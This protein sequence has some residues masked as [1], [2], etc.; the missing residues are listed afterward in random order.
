MKKH[1]AIGF[2]SLLTLSIVN[3]A[4]A[5]PG[6][7]PAAWSGLSRAYVKARP[8]VSL[9]RPGFQDPGSISGGLIMDMGIEANTRSG[10]RIGVELAPLTFAN[11][12]PYPAI[13]AH[14]GYANEF[15]GVSMSIGSGL[16]WAYPQIGPVVRIGRFT[17]AYATVRVAWS[18]YPPLPLP[19]SI[20]IDVNV[21]FTSKV[22]GNLN[23]GGGYG[24]IFGAYGTLGLQYLLS[25]DGGRRSHVLNAGL[26][27]SWMQWSLG[28]M[29]SVG[30]E[31]RF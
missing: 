15:L 11:K 6:E 29:A 31:R 2:T 20:D 24:N 5:Q 12:R 14:L 22:R 23:L 18:V 7:Q 9:A 17:G 3:V 8:F 13:F 19:V 26:G 16:A 28:P 21:P 30:Y 25:G 1:T 27:V 10:F 4:Q